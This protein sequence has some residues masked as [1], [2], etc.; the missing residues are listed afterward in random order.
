MAASASKASLPW[1]W[2]QGDAQLQPRPVERAQ[3]DII[4]Q[5]QGHHGLVGSVLIELLLNAGGMEDVPQT[6][7]AQQVDD[8]APRSQTAA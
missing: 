5:D 6:L 4:V 3:V 2:R 8:G 1:H 7:L